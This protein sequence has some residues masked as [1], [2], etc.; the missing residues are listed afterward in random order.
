MTD[1]QSDG[2]HS[3]LNH[4]KPTIIEEKK[5]QNATLDNY[6]TNL[7]QTRL[8]EKKLSA[9]ALFYKRRKRVGLLEKT[10]FMC[11]NVRILPPSLANQVDISFKI[12][13]PSN[14]NTSSNDEPEENKEG[15]WF[16][17]MNDSNLNFRVRDTKR[18]IL[19]KQIL[20]EKYLKYISLIQKKQLENTNQP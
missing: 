15:R 11:P 5:F 14:Y 20:E 4:N 18:E 13:S 17:L 6:E 8:P 7:Y 9:K 10:G 16:Y 19:L 3:L 2:S 1:K 12:R